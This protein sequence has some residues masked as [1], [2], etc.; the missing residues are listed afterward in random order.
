MTIERETKFLGA[1]AAV[2]L[3]GVYFVIV[4]KTPE[5]LPSEGA[6]ETAVPG[7]MQVSDSARRIVLSGEAGDVTLEFDGTLWRVAERDFYPASQA[8]VNGLLRGLATSAKD[9]PKTADSKYFERLGLTDRSRR[10]E[11]FDKEGNKLGGI[12]TGDQFYAPTGEGIMTFAFDDATGRAWTV[13]GLPQLS[14][15]PA[16]WLRG[17]VV[18][19]SERRLKK[20]QVQIGDT[21]PWSISKALPSSPVFTLDG[22]YGG[23]PPSPK[24]IDAAGYA[25]TGIYLEDV[26]SS[27]GL[28]L[29]KVGTATYSTFDGLSIV[30]TFYDRDGYIMTAL[31]ASYDPAVALA[32]D[33]PQVLPDVPPDGAAEAEALNAEWRGRIFQLPIETLASILKRREDLF[34]PS[35]R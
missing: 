18:T 15:H 23:A 14:L 24:M 29:F 26:A 17:D 1:L 32:D 25:I 12:L 8:E 31:E 33:T 7:F 10:I 16:Y 4:K 27:E 5:A 30:M 35:G 6:G 20:L 21:A 22:G 9:D 28:D 11:V 34:A 2:L 19:L 3:L 13:T